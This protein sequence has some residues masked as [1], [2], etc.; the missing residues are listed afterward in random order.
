MSPMR[1]CSALL[2]CLLASG[3]AVAE[4]KIDPERAKQASEA[5]E[6]GQRLFDNATENA[7]HLIA[8]GSA[9]IGEEIH[10]AEVWRQLSERKP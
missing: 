10:E 5:F 2:V 6:E 4:D 1:V 7:P 8:R 3:A 9:E